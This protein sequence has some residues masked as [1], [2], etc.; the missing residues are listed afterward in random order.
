LSGARSGRLKSEEKGPGSLQV[1]AS[2]VTAWRRQTRKEARAQICFSTGTNGTYSDAPNSGPSF[3]LCRPANSA[4]TRRPFPWTH[5]T[6]AHE[7]YLGELQELM[8]DGDEGYE[9]LDQGDF[10]TF[11]AGFGGKF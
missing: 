4:R 9:L 6:W 1:H 10:R 5:A 2:R 7:Y 11:A 8:D 3:L